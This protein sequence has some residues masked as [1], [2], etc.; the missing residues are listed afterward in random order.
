MLFIPLLV[1]E[2]DIVIDIGANSADW[3]WRLSKQVGN[4]GKVYSFE[5]D[6][7]YAN[8]TQKVIR[9]L[10]LRNVEF[11]S[12]GLSD[13]SGSAVLRIRT[14]DN[15]RVVGTGHIVEATDEN[16]TGDHQTVRVRIA[17][18][19]EVPEI[20]P[21]AKS[22]RLIKCDVEGHELHVLRG[23]VN[24][25]ERSRPVVIA[26]VGHTGYQIDNE[27]Q[28]FAFFERLD[29]DPFVVGL[30]NRSLTKSQPGDRFL[31]G[32]RPNR[33]LIPREKS[34]LLRSW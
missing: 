10:G 26:E 25:L 1:G 12:Y 19:D 11:F 2:G 8:V 30:D 22:I 4:R 27:R 29:Y 15:H 3:T 5:A 34:G 13:R 21:Y 23:A 18:L 32:T 9:L 31:V 14:P 20:K 16:Y 17:P 28:I 33:I 24:V 6:P 7:Y